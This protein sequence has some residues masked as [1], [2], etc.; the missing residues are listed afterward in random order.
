M[1]GQTLEERFWSKVNMKG[2]DECWEWRHWKQIKGYGE[3]WLSKEKPHK[4]A[5]RQAYELTYGNIPEGMLVCHTCDNKTCCN[6]KHLFVGTEKDNRQD[7][8]KKGFGYKFA[9]RRRAKLTIDDV[10]EIRELYNSGEKQI[11]L[12]RYF[13]V[14]DSCIWSIISRNSWT[15]I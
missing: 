7:A 12:A 11:D 13:G 8:I 3:F 5:H 2:E 14:S 4:L 6:P 15:N 10:L 1:K 9:S